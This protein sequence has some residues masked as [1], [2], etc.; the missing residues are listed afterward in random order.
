M[1]LQRFE[2][3]VFF[4][5][6][7]NDV[8]HIAD[9][10]AKLRAAGLKVWF[11]DGVI[12]PGELASRNVQQALD[13]S[14]TLVLFL[15][16]NA[17]R[18]EWSRLESQTLSFRDPLNAAKRFIPVRLDDSELPESLKDHLFL[19]LSSPDEP[20]GVSRLIEAC[21]PPTQPAT[22][23]GKATRRLQADATGTYE[24]VP[25]ARVTVFSGD[26]QSAVFA[27]GVQTYRVQLVRTSDSAKT[28]AVELYRFRHSVEFLHWDEEPG[29]L[30]AAST[31]TVTILDLNK[32]GNVT[33]SLDFRRVFISAAT[34][35]QG[36]LAIGLSDGSLRLSETVDAK[37]GRTLRGH[38][39]KVTCV[40]AYHSTVISGS[41]DR[42]IRLWNTSS[43][44]CIR[45]LEGHTSPIR[46]VAV[47]P[48]GRHLI[49]GDHDGE[50]RIWDL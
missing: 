3:D 24:I 29:L 38:N 39:A 2:F 8:K 32:N 37:P 47:S 12:R 30:L 25:G 26:G 36:F 14:R 34:L 15:S 5:H 28:S 44:R 6:S 33:F 13:R 10:T 48:S 42:T 46:Q 41:D 19:D 9:Y 11:D 1:E 35:G 31:K 22:T 49:S 7:K 43:G 20:T 27:S 21:R 18:D 50:I 4:A 16:E 40:C 45:V 17:G 23:P